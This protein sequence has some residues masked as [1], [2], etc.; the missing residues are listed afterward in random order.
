MGLK[1]K[2]PELAIKLRGLGK[3]PAVG[4]S[5]TNRESQSGKRLRNPQ[6]W[7][8]LFLS[9]S[10]S[11]GKY[12]RDTRK[13]PVND[14]KLPADIHHKTNR[15]KRM[16][17]EKIISDYTAYIE[18][19]RISQKSGYLKTAEKMIAYDKSCL[20]LDRLKKEFSSVRK[21]KQAKAFYSY[22]KAAGYITDQRGVELNKERDKNID[23]YYPEY[24]Q[25]LCAK[26]R[27]RLTIKS[28]RLRLDIFKNYLRESESFKL[29]E[30][31]SKIIENFK[32]YLY[33]YRH[34]NTE[35]N[36]SIKMQISCLQTVKRYFSWLFDKGYILYNPAKKVKNQRENK[37]ISMN[38]LPHKEMKKL[39][40]TIPEKPLYHRRNYVMIFL[41]Y[42]YGLRVNEAVKLRKRDIDFENKYIYIRDTKHSEDRAL[43]L[44]EPA[45]SILRDY[46]NNILPEMRKSMRKPRKMDKVK[47]SKTEKKD[48]LFLSVFSDREMDITYAGRIFKGYAEKKGGDRNLTFHSLRYS[49]AANMLKSGMSIRY[50]QECLGH[51]DID[52][53][54]KYTRVIT[55]DL[56]KAVKLFHPREMEKEKYIAEA[57]PKCK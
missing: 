43:P 36:Y 32:K 23:E 28:E 25:E 5:G 57:K 7:S 17:R 29:K 55:D 48:I 6:R 13:S 56:K 1:Q 2:N 41:S 42:F 15:S 4:F 30:I 39:L 44:I 40:E 50:I 54:D 20:T 49:F 22:L 9:D 14:K 27:S 38:Y 47:M 52:S 33:L 35:K 12:S 18:R 19:T 10:P 8:S 3:W 16:I 21:F 45:L 46:I 31:N 11:P 37:R 24:L 26:G 53:T 34:S 51:R